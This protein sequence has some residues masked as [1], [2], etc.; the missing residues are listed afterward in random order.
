MYG[1]DQ[2]WYIVITTLSFII[3]GT[4]VIMENIYDMLI[5]N[6]MTITDMKT[7]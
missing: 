7:I 3:Y 6:W 5:Y 1:Y 2:Y 4:L